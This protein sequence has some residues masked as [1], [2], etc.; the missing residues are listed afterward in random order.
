MQPPPPP[1]AAA[2]QPPPPPAASARQPLLPL[3]ASAPQ[4]PPPPAAAARQP[5]LPPA[6]SARQ[7]PPPPAACVFAARLRQRGPPQ[8]PAG[9]AKRF[10]REAAWGCNSEAPHRASC[11]AQQCGIDSAQAVS[12]PT[13][14]G[15]ATV[16]R[17]AQLGAPASK[18]S[19]GW[20][21]RTCACF[22]SRSSAALRACK[23]TGV[24]G[25]RLKGGRGCS[26]GFPPWD[27]PNSS[28]TG[29]TLR[30]GTRGA[31]AAAPAPVPAGQPCCHP[32]TGRRWA[33]WHFRRWLPACRCAGTVPSTAQSTGGTV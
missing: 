13:G 17:A 23:P 7:L 3:A 2:R 27:A 4:L 11:S 16:K 19:G 6:A 15:S 33:G 5:L 26:Q 1:A 9:R 31:Q 8:P 21:A 14:S 25:G 12:A 20:R 30:A 32:V 29:C 22:S 10:Q 24:P 28:R 18:A